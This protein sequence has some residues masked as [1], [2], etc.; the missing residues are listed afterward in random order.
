MTMNNILETLKKSDT[1]AITFHQSPDGDALGS[2]LALMIGLRALGK[3]AYILSKDKIPSVYSFLP[4][5]NEITGLDYELKS[6]TDCLVVLDCGN[7]ERSSANINLNHSYKLI[8]ID[9]HLSNDLYAD[10]NY[11]DT[12]AAAT[13]EIVYRI[14]KLM[15]LEIDKNIAECIYTA[16]LTDTGSFRHSNT[17]SITHNIAGDL[18]NTGIDFS[19]IHRNIF[20]SKSFSRLK[21]YGKILNEME[22]YFNNKLCIACINKDLSEQLEDTSDIISLQMQIDSIEVAVLLKEVE[23]GVKVSLRSKD[24]FDVRMIAETFGGGGHTKASGLL[25]KDTDL[26]TAKTIILNTLEKEL[27]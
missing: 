21:L 26:N 16:L 8:N 11:I 5:V 22:L 12:K 17:T 13:G 15:D 25:L 3:D 14:L 24:K 2:S 20:E 19:R 23:V 10:Y 4:Y 9:H 27:I 18:I 6:N 1:I 7:I